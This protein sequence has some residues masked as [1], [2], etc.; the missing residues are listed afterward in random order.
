LLKQLFAIFILFALAFLVHNAFAQ[1]PYDVPNPGDYLT[2]VSNTEGNEQTLQLPIK[3]LLFNVTPHNDQNGKLVSLSLEL[4]PGLDSLYNDLGF[5]NKTKD[6]VFI[7]PSF[8]QAAYGNNGFYDFYNNKCDISCLTVKIPTGIH[9]TQASSIAGA[10]ALKLLK[11]PY[12]KDEDIDKNPDILKQYK[13]V[14]VL[15][16]E[17]VTKK[18]YDAITSHPNVIFLYPNALYAQVSTN[19]TDN[20]ITLVRGHGYPNLN[21]KNGFGWK[22]DNSRYE[23]DVDCPNWYFYMRE[24]Y[25]LL[26]CYPEYEILVDEQL[27]RSLQ[28]PKPSHLLSDIANWSRYPEDTESITNLLNEF[29]IPGSHIPD[30]VHNPANLVL[31]NKIS[32]TDFAHLM[33]YLHDQNI[34]K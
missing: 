1:S 3:D 13:R 30:W 20:T 11:Y 9:G 10:W 25:T 8:T 19:Y 18:E 31:N 7:Y 27:L 22:Y 21:V 4:K 23:Y 15:H 29:G 14:I 26:N 16:N 32:K 28:N 34:I 2:V 33:I 12:L 6:T 5:F 24:N 17:Y